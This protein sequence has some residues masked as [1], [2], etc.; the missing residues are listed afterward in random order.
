[1]RQS[2]MTLCLKRQMRYPCTLSY[3]DWR[4]ASVAGVHEHFKS[5]G[6]ISKASGG[7]NTGWSVLT[8]ISGSPVYAWNGRYVW[9]VT[10]P[11]PEQ[12][13]QVHVDG[14]SG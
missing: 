1:M 3:P 12:S 2:T 10:F 13:S 8:A 14:D 5:S 7:A 6:R 4:F 9:L 11:L